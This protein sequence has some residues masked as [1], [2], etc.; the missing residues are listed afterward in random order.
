MVL[1]DF[2]TVA[3][4]HSRFADTHLTIKPHLT[5][6]DIRWISELREQLEKSGLAVDDIR[7]LI[8]GAR[9]FKDHGFNVSEMLVTFSEY[10]GRENAIS[11][12]ERQL[13]ILKQ[14]SKEIESENNWKV[15]LLEERRLKNSELDALKKLGSGLI[16][17]RRL[18]HIILELEEE[19][20][21]LPVEPRIVVKEFFDSLEKYYHDYLDLGKKVQELKNEVKKLK[22]VREAFID[23]L[24]LTQAT[25]ELIESL[26]R[27]GLTKDHIAEA[28]KGIEEARL[29]ASASSKEEK[30]LEKDSKSSD[31]KSEG[32]KSEKKN[33]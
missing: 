29:A 3:H 5:I 17:L 7:R 26:R 32:Q 10:K 21:A 23:F 33:P 11:G 20:G 14:K 12:Q 18:H 22:E 15:Q 13:G 6:S 9:F 25:V 28:L 31:Y 30:S 1:W 24:N 8:E 27:K 2:E 16:E 4:D 19:R